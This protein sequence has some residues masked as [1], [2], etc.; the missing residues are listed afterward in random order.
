[1]DREQAR[2]EQGQEILLVLSV[3]LY[4]PIAFAHS[5]NVR[6]RPVGPG[7]DK[8][9]GE[10]LRE[11]VNHEYRCNFF[12]WASDVKKEA[13]AQQKRRADGGGT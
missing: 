3:R 12:K 1:M 13:L 11:E 9:K 4:P 2:A 8:G 6:G 5:T 10:R 7:Y